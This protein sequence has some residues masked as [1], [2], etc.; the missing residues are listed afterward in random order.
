[1]G[2]GPGI[3]RE[4]ASLSVASQ[5]PPRRPSSIRRRSQAEEGCEYGATPHPLHV[6]VLVSRHGDFVRRA[7]RRLS[8]PPSALDDAAQQVFLITAG[9]L[10]DVPADR[11]RA[12]LVGVATNVAAHA[13][14]GL[15]RRREVDLEDDAAA[16]LSMQDSAPLPDEA[17]DAVRLSALVEDTLAALPD[18]LRCVLVLVEIE[19]RTM[20]EA[21]VLLGVPPGTIASRLRRARTTMA[22]AIARVRPS[23]RMRAAARRKIS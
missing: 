20:A 11:A 3:R 9:K 19:E 8:V 10:D 4:E 14:R 16:G 1:M 18:A 6:A 13:R 23:R 2:A 17:L 7:L 15:A 21:A 12:F 5:P 22:T